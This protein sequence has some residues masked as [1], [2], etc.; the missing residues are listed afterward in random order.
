MT[1]SRAARRHPALVATIGAVA[2]TLMSIKKTGDFH[3]G[4]PLRILR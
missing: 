4:K 2:L 3:S 1:A